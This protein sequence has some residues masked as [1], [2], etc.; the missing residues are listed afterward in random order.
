MD[1]GNWIAVGAAA[2]SAVSATVGIWQARIARRAAKTADA[3]RD[4]AS[5]QAHSARDSADSARKSSA[6]SIAQANIA[7]DQ[8]RLRDRSG[9]TS[10]PKRRCRSRF[11]NFG[12]ARCWQ[13]HFIKP[14]G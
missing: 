5:D 3:Q 12:L 10:T 8:Y 2:I 13:D 14:I 7:H 11:T 4:L 9:G 1:G 6:A